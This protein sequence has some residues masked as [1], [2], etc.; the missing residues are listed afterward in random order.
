M[1]F[2]ALISS[3]CVFVNNLRMIYL[4]FLKNHIVCIELRIIMQGSIIFQATK[5]NCF[6][7]KYFICDSD[8]YHSGFYCFKRHKFDGH[9]TASFKLCL[10]FILF[11]YAYISS[12]SDKLFH[13][14]ATDKIAFLF[15]ALYTALGCYHVRHKYSEF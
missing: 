11:M 9:S 10:F 2:L 4:F 14:R 8:L 5:K 12:R 13:F 6:P 1:L 3:K 7:C 15:L